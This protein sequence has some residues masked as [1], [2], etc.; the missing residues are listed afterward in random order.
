VTDAADDLLAPRRAALGVV[1]A[2]LARRGGLEEALNARAMLGLSVQDRG[3]ARALAMTTLRR[4]GQIDALLA[5][6]LQREPP[7]VARA[8]LRIGVAQAFWMDTPAFAAVDTAVELAPKPLRGLVNAVLRGLLRGPPPADDPATLA[9]DWLFARWRQ[10][11]GDSAARDVAAAIADEPATDVT[12]KDV[13]DEAALAAALEAEALPGGTLRTR[14]G[15]DVSTWPGFAEG[16]WWVQDAAAAIPARLLRAAAGESALDMCAAPGGKTFQLAANG[17]A[18]TALDRSPARLKRVSEG[19][20]RLGLTAELD[21]GDAAEWQPERRFDAVLLDAP[22]SATGTF[23][24]HPDVLWNVRPGDIGRMAQTQATLLDAAADHLRTRGRLV[25]SVCSLEP[26]EG[27]AQITALLARRDDVALEPIAAREGG[28][29]A[30][31]LTA[32]GT[33]RILPTHLD[34]GIDGFFI[35]RLRKR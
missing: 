4:L 30:A 20:A 18:T 27:E 16:R 24:R 2:A 28:S 34:G 6:R 12:L 21:A 26:E 13:G 1:E 10:A 9:P 29:P 8:L 14:R 11:F 15:G 17:A 32:A 3:F 25:Y 19:L 5:P 33:L 35:A 23:R 31:S 22:C 7:P